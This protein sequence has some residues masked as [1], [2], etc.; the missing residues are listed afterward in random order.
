MGGNNVVGPEGVLGSGRR[1]PL[2]LEGRGVG[3]GAG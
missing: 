3:D 2:M 1:G